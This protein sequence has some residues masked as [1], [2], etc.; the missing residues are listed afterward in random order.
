MNSLGNAFSGS[1]CQLTLDQ[2][3]AGAAGAVVLAGTGAPFGSTAEQVVSLR[4]S[5]VSESLVGAAV[6]GVKSGSEALRVGVGDWDSSAICL[7]E[8]PAEAAAD[9]L[10][11]APTHPDS[12][13]HPPAN[14][15]IINGA[16]CLSGCLFM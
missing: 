15:T 3:P 1:F 13:A 14:T 10:D 2:A 9:G 4:S 8:D 12:S 6:R 16:R 11:P 5:D 7:A